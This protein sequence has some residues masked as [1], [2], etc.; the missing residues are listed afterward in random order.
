MFIGQLFISRYTEYFQK[1]Y[2]KV[3]QSRTMLV[4]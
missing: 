3:K 4:V 1:N 2:M